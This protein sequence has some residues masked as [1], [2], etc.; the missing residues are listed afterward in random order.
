MKRRC[1]SCWQEFWLTRGDR[2]YG[3]VQCT[4]CV[5]YESAR[6]LV[7]TGDTADQ[8]LAFLFPSEFEQEKRINDGVASM[9]AKVLGSVT[10]G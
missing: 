8:W 4:P 5:R 7:G 2:E 10:D 3:P 6:R 1:L 9:V